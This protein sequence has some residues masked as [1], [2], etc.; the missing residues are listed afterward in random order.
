MGKE[1]TPLQR[2]HRQPARVAGCA[3]LLCLIASGCSGTYSGIGNKAPPPRSDFPPAAGKTLT[4]LSAQSDGESK[5]VLAPTGEVFDRGSDRYGF[6]VFT[7]GRKQI[8]DA[9]VA[10]YFAH[11][12][13][14]KALGPYPARVESLA[15]ESAYIAQSTGQDPQAGKVVYVIDNAPFHADG[16]WRILA[17]VSDGGGIKATIVPSA[18]VGH[19]PHPPPG[20]PK[21]PPNPPDVGKAAPRVHTP[22]AGDVEGDLRKIDTRIPPDQ[23]HKDDL[24]EVLGREPVVLLFAT[25]QFCQSRVCGPVVDEAEQ[26][27]Q[28]D[29]KGVAFIHMEI[30]KDN[31][32]SLGARPQVKAFRLESEPWLF[33]IDR[34]GIIRTRIEGAWSIPELERALREARR[35]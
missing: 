20:E 15:T 26:V 4:D 10:L 24:A 1:E 25:P 31:S 18:V 21:S 33:V 12:E 34:Q 8:T 30:Y 2:R 16:E 9:K 5:L 22:T 29:G 17:M 27:N 19:F 28:T 23:M 3:V 6:G 32:P 7:A 35:R 14:G 13:E 11:G